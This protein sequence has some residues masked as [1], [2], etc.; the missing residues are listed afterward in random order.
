MRGKSGP[1][2]CCQNFDTVSRIRNPIRKSLFLF[3]FLPADNVSKSTW[4][5]CTHR[6]NSYNRWMCISLWQTDYTR[7]RLGATCLIKYEVC[8]R[9][10]TRDWRTSFVFNI[11]PPLLPPTRKRQKVGRTQVFESADKPHREV[12]M[13]VWLPCVSVSGVVNR[14]RLFPRKKKRPRSYN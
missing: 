5:G 8:G 3:S 2:F 7:D 13:V 10:M 11:S 14:F 6:R 1:A 4:S 9:S 12:D